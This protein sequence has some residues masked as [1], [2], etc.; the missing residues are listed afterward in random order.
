MHIDAVEK[1]ARAEWCRLITET[2]GKAGG[3]V[4]RALRGGAGW[5]Y[6][7]IVGVLGALAFVLLWSSLAMLVVW[8][9]MVEVQCST[10]RANLD[11]RGWE[12]GS[13]G[14]MG[15]LGRGLGV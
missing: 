12:V 7:S 6:C 11:M 5:L 14:C 2:K 1:C 4:V 10:G 15:A 8:V 9:C 3:G 13:D